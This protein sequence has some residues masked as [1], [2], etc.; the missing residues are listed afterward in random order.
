M[1]VGIE[2]RKE[3]SSPVQ[4]LVTIL[5]LASMQYINKLATTQSQ[6]PCPPPKKKNLNCRLQRAVSEN[7]ACTQN[8]VGK[9]PGKGS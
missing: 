3:W 4:G 1:K 2:Y 6:K 5:R 8:S 7:F 9:G